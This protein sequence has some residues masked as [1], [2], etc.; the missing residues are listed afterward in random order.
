M[1]FRI[2]TDLAKVIVDTIWTAM[3]AGS[4]AATLKVYSGSQPATVETSPS[5]TLLATFTLN[6]PSATAA[7]T[8]STTFINAGWVTSPPITATVAATGT[9]GWF[10]VAASDGTPVF[11]GNC[12]T[13]SEPLTFDSVSWTSGDTVTLSSAGAYLITS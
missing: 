8:L 12:G 4:G 13:G 7:T 6:D 2:S 11:D 1:P 10:R 5:G 9:A 3:D